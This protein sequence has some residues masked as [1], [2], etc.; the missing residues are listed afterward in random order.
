M[1]R[2]KVRNLSKLALGCLLALGVSHAQ[3]STITPQEW[4]TGSN[5][6]DLGLMVWD[7][8]AATSYS[9][10]LNINLLSFIAQ[11]ATTN[12]TWNLDSVFTSFAATGDALTFN[13]AAANIGTP[14]PSYVYQDPNDSIMYSYQT[15]Q[16]GSNYIPANMKP[17][18]VIADQGKV[19]GE[20][21]TQGSTGSEVTSYTLSTA[22]F[23]NVQWGVGQNTNQNHSAVYRGTGTDSLSVDIISS[24]GSS[25]IAAT[26]FPVHL[27][28]GY[29]SLSEV[30][31]S[32]LLTW[33]SGATAT[34]TVPEP[35]EI[36]LFLTGLASLLGLR[37]RNSVSQV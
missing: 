25:T 34:A 4:T 33:S 3:A 20:W 17:N 5:L 16:S 27:P 31:G 11:E 35:A 26:N 7:Q 21:T 28:I 36:G 12:M 10:D 8:N 15:G 30:S 19:Q 9:V 13:I 2:M 23:N 22:Y 6:T 37:K 14:N 29:F 1:Q 18:T 24:P 32:Y